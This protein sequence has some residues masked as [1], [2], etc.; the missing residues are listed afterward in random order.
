MITYKHI[1]AWS[2]IPIG[3]LA[4]T[5]YDCY[6]YLIGY[7]CTNGTDSN[8]ISQSTARLQHPFCEF[9]F[10]NINTSDDVL[11]IVNLKLRYIKG[12]ITSKEFYDQKPPVNKENIDIEV[13]HIEGDVYDDWID[14][15]C[16]Y[17]TKFKT[18]FYYLYHEIFYKNITQS[19]EYPDNVGKYFRNMLVFK[20]FFVQVPTSIGQSK[21]I[22]QE[23]PNQ[24]NPPCDSTYMTNKLCLQEKIDNIL[25]S[26]W[27]NQENINKLLD[28][29]KKIEF[30]QSL[31]SRMNETQD[32]KK[33]KQN[34]GNL[35]SQFKILSGNDVQLVQTEFS[36]V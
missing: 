27:G 21:N 19:I 23:E 4:S 14:G 1:S 9:P 36:D 2:N 22:P 29:I 3:G 18:L 15:V 32:I 12:E 28:G 31:I 35:I 33:M 7:S 16:Y 24:E 26:F 5:Y 30:K 20:D 8:F 13:V 10:W 11:D 6:I 34:Y 17:N 25:K